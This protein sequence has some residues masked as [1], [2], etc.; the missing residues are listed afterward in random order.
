MVA[1][2]PAELWRLYTRLVEI[3]QAFK[4]LKHDLAVR[5]VF[6]QVE[7]R[8]EAHI[9]VSFI[10]CCL[11]G[12]QKNIARPHAGGLTPRAIIEAFGTIQMVDAHLPTTDGRHLVLPRYTQPR[13]EL[14]LLLHQLGMTLPEQGA[15]RL[16]S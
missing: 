11:P 5:P 3:E 2:D 16:S 4:E 9:F 15:P 6:H 10:A 12:N 13:K 8:I 7:E 1:E 14:E